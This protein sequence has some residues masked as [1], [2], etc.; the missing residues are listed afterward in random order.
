MV[1][2]E[3]AA[4]W[5]PAGH[6]LV[7]IDS[8]AC[9]P[10]LELLLDELLDEELP[11]PDEELLLLLLDEPLPE[12][13]LP[14]PEDELPP[15]EPLPLLLDTR[16]LEVPPEELVLEA[17]LVDEPPPPQAVRVSDRQDSTGSSRRRRFMLPLIASKPTAVK[18]SPSGDGR[19]RDPGH[20]LL[21]L[22][23][24]A[25]VAAMNTII[26]PATLFDCEELASLVEQYWK[27]EQ[28]PGFRQERIVR[29]LRTT[30]THSDRGGCWV[31]G[32]P[33]A[34]RGYLLAVYL[35]S[36][37]F[38]GTIAEIDEFYVLD[39]HRCAGVGTRLARHAIAE[40]K[41]AGVLHV[42]LQV[43]TENR[44]GR[45]FYERLGFGTR[46]GYELLS[47]DL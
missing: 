27:F 35:F 31:A 14:A 47:L 8:A 12:E 13:L 22:R 40:M 16:L 30:I 26:R 29:L 46:T 15:E 34:L 38:G 7:V 33:G 25:T 1:Q 20:R 37:E 18:M 32:E 39:T 24:H 21:S 2:P 17:L 10:P 41:Q 42:Q 5:V 28:I 3:Y 23:D 11:D 9:E 19:F 43:G 45:A 36:L 44:S 4:P 6:V